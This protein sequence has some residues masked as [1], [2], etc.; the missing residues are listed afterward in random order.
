MPSSLS[1][2][3]N[4][5]F[6]LSSS[7]SSS[8]PSSSSSTTQ[9][10][11]N[12]AKILS[13]V[14]A[15]KL[16]NHH[17]MESFHSSQPD[18]TLVGILRILLVLVTSHTELRKMLGKYPKNI[19]KSLKIGMTRNILHANNDH[20]DNEIDGTKR[21]QINLNNDRN[22]DENNDDNDNE[23]DLLSFLYRNC[24]FPEEKDRIMPSNPNITITN[25]NNNNNNNNERNSVPPG[26]YTFQLMLICATIVHNHSL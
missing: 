2:S 24:L 11:N 25:D 13:E 10:W 1:L 19:P 7:S 3:S 5:Q 18:G 21:I 12:D 4:I 8:S 16:M 9:K 22:N 20:H 14:F 15:T 17:S 6:N 26:A 23:N